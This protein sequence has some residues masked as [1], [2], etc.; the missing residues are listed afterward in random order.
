MEL[1]E[2]LKKIE[3]SED[4][5]MPIKELALNLLRIIEH[6]AGTF[7]DLDNVWNS[8]IEPLCELAEVDYDKVIGN[9]HTFT[10]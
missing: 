5:A 7:G 4:G 6:K 8:V 2:V 3:T 1:K 10:I 9:W